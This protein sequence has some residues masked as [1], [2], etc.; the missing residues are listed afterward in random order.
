MNSSNTFDGLR[1]YPISSNA[2]SSMHLFWNQGIQLFKSVEATIQVNNTPSSKDIYF[3]ALQVEFS[4]NGKRVGGAHTGLQHHNSYP[5]SSAINWG[6]Y[7][8][9]GLELDGSESELTSAINNQNTR[10]YPWANGVA[11]TYK[12]SQSLNSKN[13]TASVRNNQTGIETVI[14]ELF[15]DADY[16]AAPMVWTECFARCDAESV[17]V[18]WSDLKTIDQDG[19]VTNIDQVRVNYQ[20]LS[21]GGC[22]NTNSSVS[23]NNFVQTTNTGRT[24]LDGTLLSINN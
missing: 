21:D 8:S 2:A 9:E 7:N 23:N 13:W 1:N 22:I 4:K 19:T 17:S 11:Y 5:S 12:I 18:N 20:K 3:W 24:N 16:I 14:R 15:I 10:D 6:G